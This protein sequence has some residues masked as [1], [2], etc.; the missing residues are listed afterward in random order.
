VA[1][2][3]GFT[4]RVAET[5]QDR[6]TYRELAQQAIHALADLTTK[7]QRQTARLHELL[8]ELRRQQRPKAAA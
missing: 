6:D 3:S 1:H 4:D 5:T 7:L 8:D 2:D